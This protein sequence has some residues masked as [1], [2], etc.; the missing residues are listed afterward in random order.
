MKEV[1][2]DRHPRSVCYLQV[3]H[4]CWYDNSHT[5]VYDNRHTLIIN[6]WGVELM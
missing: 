2:K 1:D 6:D 5:C 4:T 3:G